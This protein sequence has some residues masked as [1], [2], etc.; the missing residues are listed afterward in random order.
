MVAEK[1]I[2]S[3]DL[4]DTLRKRIL[5]LRTDT[6]VKLLPERELSSEFGVSRMTLRIAIKKLKDEGLLIQK[7]GSGTYIS[8]VATFEQIN[9]LIAPDLKKDDPFYTAFMSEVHQLLS[10]KNISIKFVDFERIGSIG[11]E[12]SPLIIIGIIDEVQIKR[13][14]DSF[15]HTV[16]VHM[17]PDLDNLSQVFFDDYGIGYRAATKLFERG[18]RILVHLAGPLKYPS[19]RF[20][21]QGFHN[22]A[23]RKGLRSIELQGKMNYNCGVNMFPDIMK[24][25]RNANE[26]VGVFASNDWMALGLMHALLENGVRIP[27]EISIIGCDDIPLAS[28]REPTL[29]TFRWDFSLLLNEILEEFRIMYFSPTYCQKKVLLNAEYIERATLG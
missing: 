25:L 19:P 29:T 18:H 15:P 3:T 16:S 13:V 10:K 4:F 8:S 11:R 20:R 17:Y 1:L 24:L 5:E 28:Q 6:P 12:D 22:A 27:E 2:K 7:Q 26:K 14:I 21:S 9:F 23:E